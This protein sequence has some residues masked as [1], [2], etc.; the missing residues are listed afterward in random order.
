M[1]SKS[2]F[3]ALLVLSLLAVGACRRNGVDVSNTNITGSQAPGPD[4]PVPEFS[5]ADAAL[6]EGKRLLESGETEKAIQALDQAVRLNP[7]LAEGYF[8]LGIAWSLIEV[9]EKTAEMNGTAE[10]TPEPTKVVTNKGDKKELR[11]LRANSEKYFKKAASAYQKL[12]DANGEDA[13][14]YFN[15]GRAYN[16]LNEDEDAEKALRQAVKLNPDDTEFQT[17]LGA[18]L[19]KL[20]KYGDAVA[21]LKKA[22]ELDADNSKAQDLLDDAEAGQKRVAYVTKPKDDKKPG[23]NSNTAPAGA[24]TPQI[25]DDTPPP[26][27]ADRPR[28]VNPRPTPAPTRQ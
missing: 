3:C 14:A 12:I 4:Q 2:F 13:T 28:T 9:R 18:I 10:P 23:A 1:V 6:A 27:P 25:G 22:L 20:A 24:V 8:Q 16:K 26:P 19:I 11:V 15:L 7:D 17:E 21:A 5:D